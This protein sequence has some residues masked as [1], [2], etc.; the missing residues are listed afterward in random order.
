MRTF[1]MVCGE[2]VA[3]DE[4]EFLDIEEGVQ[5]EDIMTFRYKGQV[6]KQAVVSRG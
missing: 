3:T 2:W 5:G 6:Y 1:V 4:V